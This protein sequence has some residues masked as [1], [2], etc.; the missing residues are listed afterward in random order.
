MSRIIEPLSKMGAEIESAAD[1]P[2]APLIIKKSAQALRSIEY[3]SPVASAQVKSCV[4]AAGL[5]AEGNTKV[6]EPFLSRDHSE[7]MLKYFSAHISTEGLTTQIKGGCE[8]TSKDIEIPG[9]IS[10]AAFFI[11]AAL[12]IPGSHLTIHNVGLNPTRIGVINVLKRMGGDI[13]I[14]DLKEGVEPFGDIE[15]K[16]SELNSTTVSE[17]EIPLLID[18]IPVLAVAALRAKGTTIIKGIKELKVKETDRVKSITDNFLVMGVNIAEEDNS[19]IIP[20]DVN[21]I[22]ASELDSFGDHRIAMS[23]AIASLLADGDCLIKN[24]E[25]VDTSYPGFLSDLEKLRA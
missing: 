7:R 18:E 8:L 22:K 10:S 1:G 9:D 4:L 16:A 19:L 3:N 25:C 23:M 17:E 5:Y 6:T 2:H 13:N 12:V 14:L 21:S 24:V 15:I 20:G 11:V